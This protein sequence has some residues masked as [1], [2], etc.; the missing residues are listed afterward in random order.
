MPIWL[1]MWSAIAEI[2]NPDK[3]VGE[4]AWIV[5]TLQARWST[6]LSCVYEAVKTGILYH[7]VVSKL[8]G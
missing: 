8:I 4:E 3:A 5:S 6:T 7:G 1:V 2:N